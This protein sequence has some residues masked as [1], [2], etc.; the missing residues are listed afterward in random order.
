MS[1]QGR[2]PARRQQ[3]LTAI[4]QAPEPPGV[5]EIAA[6][7]G[8]HLNTARF[9]LANLEADGIIE[10]LL[11]E[12]SGPGRPPVTY[13]SRRGQALGDVRRYQVLAEV[14]L[15]HLAATGDAPA[16]EHAGEAWGAHLVNRPAPH[17]A[18]D[19]NEAVRLLIQL[20]AELDFAPEYLTETP[21]TLPDTGPTATS[22]DTAADSESG[23][24]GIR[25]RHCPFLELADPHRNLVCA[26]HL[27][28][29][30]GALSELNAPVTVTDLQP[31]AEPAACLAHLALI[32]A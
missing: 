13:R 8:I 30:R 11:G 32:S 19:Y 25:L 6:R 16:A 4:Q 17:H 3:V 15:S 31:F 26:M 14:L 1:G 27:G 23:P 12:A 9:H 5:A 10:R 20:L 24:A 2:T 21:P 28:L 22:T 7:V 18:V 29:M